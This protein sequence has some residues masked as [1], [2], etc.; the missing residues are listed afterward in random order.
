M[1]RLKLKILERFEKPLRSIL[2]FNRYDE[3]VGRAVLED[4]YGKE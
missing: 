4:L 1:K 3:M 2:G